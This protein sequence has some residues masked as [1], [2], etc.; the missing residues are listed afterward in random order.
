MPFAG[1]G[2]CLCNGP[3]PALSGE[4]GWRCRLWDGGEQNTG[5]ARSRARVGHLGAAKPLPPALLCGAGG[6]VGLGA[7]PPYHVAVPLHQPRR[8]LR[9]SEAFKNSS[10]F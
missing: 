6:D 9:S 10:L 8:F 3:R 2:L 7:G 1:A 5:A 4:P